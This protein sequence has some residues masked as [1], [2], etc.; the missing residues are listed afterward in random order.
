M[1]ILTE[2]VTSIFD[3]LV[4]DPGFLTGGTNWKDVDA[5]LLFGQFSQ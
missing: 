4:A 3:L 5:N 2:L 1:G